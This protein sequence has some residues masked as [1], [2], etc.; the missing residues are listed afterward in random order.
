[1]WVVRWTFYPTH[2]GKWCISVPASS[3]LHVCCWLCNCWKW[4]FCQ[5]VFC[6]SYHQN[7]STN[8]VGSRNNVP[9]QPRQLAATSCRVNCFIFISIQK[10]ARIFV[11]IFRVHAM[12]CKNNLV[13][14]GVKVAFMC[15]PHKSMHWAYKLLF[16]YILSYVF[17]KL[18]QFY[19]SPLMQRVGPCIFSCPFFRLRIMRIFVL[20]I[21][22]VIMSKVCIISHCLWLYHEIMVCDVCHDLN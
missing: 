17:L 1:M 2:R 10:E 22:I 7:R 18:S 9:K 6:V 5:Q 13:Y 20:I 14:Y 3:R 16:S 21:I 19:Q 15:L 11:P 4:S 12:M 8:L